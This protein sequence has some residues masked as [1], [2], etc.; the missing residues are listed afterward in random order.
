MIIDP[1]SHYD[2]AYWSAAK[3]YRYRN[4]DGSIEERVYHGPALW[5]DG[6]AQLCDALL[7]ALDIAPG[8]SLLDIGCG[9]G[10]FT[11]GF[12]R[13]GL[14]AYGVDIS[15][16][17]VSKAP[18]AVRGRIFHGDALDGELPEPL[19]RSF[20]LCAAFDIVEHIYA[21][22]QP[23]LWRA[24]DRTGAKTLLLDIGTAHHESEIWVH[25][26]GK[27]VP[28]AHEVTAVS[29]HVL[30]QTIAFWRTHARTWGWQPD[31][32]AMAKFEAWR[33]ATPAYDQLIAWGPLHLLLLRR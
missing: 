17:A 23:K 28:L 14:D 26:A 31:D 1:S 32:D 2:D 8:A 13:R 20:D 18:T 24:F 7:M 33:A 5:W 12:Q 11:A 4:P 27:P 25:E 6:A 15:E 10:C 16:Y 3:T 9:A 22:D 30:V 19:R 29:G 21:P